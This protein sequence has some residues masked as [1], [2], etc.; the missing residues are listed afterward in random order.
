MADVRYQY[1]GYELN[2]GE[3]WFASYLNG[4][5]QT[6]IPLVLA[7]QKRELSAMDPADIEDELKELYRLKGA[8]LEKEAYLIGV[9]TQTSGALQRGQMGL[10]ATGIRAGADVEVARYQGQVKLTEQDREFLNQRQNSIILTDADAVAVEQHTNA[11]RSL[12]PQGRQPTAQEMRVVVQQTAQ[13]ATKYLQGIEN[14]LRRA[15]VTN[16][17]V[18]RLR[19][20]GGIDKAP[21]EVRQA[22]EEAVTGQLMQPLALQPVADEAG[23]VSAVT[24]SDYDTLLEQRAVAPSAPVA[25]APSRLTVTPLG[26]QPAAQPASRGRGVPAPAPEPA[27]APGGSQPPSR[28]SSAGASTAGAA[29][30]AS[31][32][33][34]RAVGPDTAGARTEAPGG[35]FSQL[36]TGSTV[37]DAAG[38]AYQGIPSFNATLTDIDRRILELRDRQARLAD[39]ASEESKAR[40]QI[41]LDLW[42]RAPEEGEQ[43]FFGKLGQLLAADPAKARDFLLLAVERVRMKRAGGSPRDPRWVAKAQREVFGEGEGGEPIWMVQDGTS[44]AMQNVAS[45]YAKLANQ[46]VDAGLATLN[47]DGSVTPTDRL[48]VQ[49]LDEFAAEAAD[50]LLEAG[51]TPEGVATAL[52]NVPLP[53]SVRQAVYDTYELAEADRTARKVREE[54]RALEKP[55]SD[56]DADL[57]KGLKVEAEAWLSGRKAAAD[58]GDLSA[59]DAVA[60]AQEAEAQAAAMDRYNPE[61]AAFARG[62]AAAFREAAAEKD[63]RQWTPGE[64]AALRMEGGVHGENMMTAMPSGTNNRLPTTTGVRPTTAPEVAPVGGSVHM[65][66]STTPVVDFMGVPGRA[67][68]TVWQDVEARVR[69]RMQGQPEDA[70]QAELARLRSRRTQAQVQATGGM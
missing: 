39:P 29:T 20:A 65:G 35:A 38:V 2:P 10:E 60:R 43:A 5:M 13:E 63:P 6:R 30:G 11:A 68:D 64:R 28:A 67:F 4:F 27:A 32:A 1:R 56:L 9:G 46:L 54:Y 50:A 24:Q 22:F 52:G 7:K 31:G 14:P 16:R 45:G 59:E 44:T 26:A 40:R 37:V 69:A 58:A 57:P 19:D 53:A 17:I 47:P 34:A 49:Q 21:P 25:R 15:A 55:M 3:S 8:L 18:E 48:A 12:I 36:P 42:T 62:Q 61:Y 66:P 41:E 51:A 70:I 33:P 23:R